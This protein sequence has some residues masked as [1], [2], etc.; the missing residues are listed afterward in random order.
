MTGKRLVSVSRVEN[1][2]PVKT[3][4]HDK[5]SHIKLRLLLFNGAIRVITV[6][7]FI[8]CESDTK[9]GENNMRQTGK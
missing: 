6:L 8:A 9:Y 5:G 7:L 3:F 4:P 2:S 1:H